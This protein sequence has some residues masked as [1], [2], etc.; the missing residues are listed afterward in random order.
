MYTGL[1][2]R[3]RVRETGVAGV[4]EVAAQG[5]VRN[6][7]FDARNERGYLGRHTDPDR[8]GEADLV[9]LAGRDPLRDFNY[10]IERNLA[11]EWATEGG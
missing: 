1:G 3:K 11:L 6:T 9:G 10:P 8:V 4:V 5:N 7:G 2:G